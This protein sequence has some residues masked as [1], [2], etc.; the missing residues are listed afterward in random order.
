[1]VLKQLLSVT[2]CLVVRKKVKVVIIILSLLS[3]TMSWDAIGPQKLGG[4]TFH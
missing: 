2:V 4:D 1:M 3:V